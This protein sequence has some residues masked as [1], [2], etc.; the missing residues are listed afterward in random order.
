MATSGVKHVDKIVFVEAFA[1][2]VPSSATP[3]CVSLKYFDHITFLIKYKNATTVTG[4]A[5]TINQGTSGAGTT[6]LA[7]T[8]ALAFT[9]MYA[10]VNAADTH[11]MT[12]TAVVSSTF[13]TDSTN[14][15][16]GLYIVEISAIDLDVANKFNTIQI[17]LGNATAA[18]I[19]VWYILG[20]SPRYSGG[21]DS[22]GNPMAD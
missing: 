3:T 20:P 2:A 12:E 8:K 9:K 18:T 11:N 7:G 1:P 21:Y 22:F 10:A 19:Q 17:G 6:T 14:S 16:S 5:V 4:T 13:T 15:Q